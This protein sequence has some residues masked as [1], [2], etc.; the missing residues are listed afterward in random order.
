MTINKQLTYVFIR[1]FLLTYSSTSTLIE[2]II[3]QVSNQIDLLKI[4]YNIKDFPVQDIITSILVKRSDKPFSVDSTNATF[5]VGNFLN[6]I[7]VDNVQN[8]L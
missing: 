6:I 2:N 3:N 7:F 5:F 4:T 8:L 1:I